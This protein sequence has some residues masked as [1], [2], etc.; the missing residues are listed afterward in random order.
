MHLLSR[1]V[2]IVLVATVLILFTSNKEREGL[3]KWVE[4]TKIEGLFS[5]ETTSQQTAQPHDTLGEEMVADKF[6]DTGDKL[7]ASSKA[8]GAAASSAFKASMHQA[9]ITKIN[10]V[11]LPRAYTK[12]GK[13]VHGQDD[14]RKQFP[15]VSNRIT[16]VQSKIASLQLDG[17]DDD[18]AK[19]FTDKAHKVI[20]DQQLTKHFGELGILVI[21]SGRGIVE[22]GL[23]QGIS[24]GGSRVR[25]GRFFEKFLGQCQFLIG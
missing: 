10:N 22:C 23:Q 18:S 17:K 20:L 3:E 19:S 14:I 2:T 9:E 5:E 15:E 12:L 21:E 7:K 13:A 24:T 8:F 4:A 1:L 16:E 25:G 6:H 11:N